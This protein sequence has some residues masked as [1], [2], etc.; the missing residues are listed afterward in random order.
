MGSFR[1]TTYLTIEELRQIASA[2]FEEAAALPDG[3]QREQ[4]LKSAHG[5]RS[6]A[7]IK[8]GWLSSDVQPPKR[9]GS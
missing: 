4:V 9:A 2:K 1:P 3:P 8:G 5:F 6:L 7:E